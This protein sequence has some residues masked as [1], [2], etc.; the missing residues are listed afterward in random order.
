MDY[1]EI[2]DDCFY[3]CSQRGY[4][5]AGQQG[6]KCFCSNVLPA[7]NTKVD[8]SQCRCYCS[9]DFSKYC[10][11]DERLRVFHLSNVVLQAKQYF[12]NI[13]YVGC[14]EDQENARDLNGTSLYSQSMTLDKCFHFCD[15][16]GYH[17]A[18]LQNQ[19]YCY[20]DD[21]Y[22]AYQKVSSEQCQCI[23]SGDPSKYCGCSGVNR[24]FLLTQIGYSL[25]TCCEY[26]V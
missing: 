2:P 8:N 4:E 11:C 7:N 3:F 25:P 6:S 12:G 9:G 23:C 10:G 16:N 21:S 18:G 19:S 13:D 26:F 1:Q 5:L 17:Y 22:G 24:V 15:T 14:W 20:C